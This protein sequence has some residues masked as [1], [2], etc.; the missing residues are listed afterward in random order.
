GRGEEAAVA[1]ATALAEERK[2]AVINHEQGRKQ[3]FVDLEQS[4]DNAQRVRGD[5]AVM[6]HEAHE[7]DTA[8]AERERTIPA[9]VRE[10]PP[11]WA[12]W[13]WLMIAYLALFRRD[14]WT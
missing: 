3:A 7:T 10:R 6:E 1:E 2:Q 4:R 9:S 5:A 13:L 11:W 8:I 12:F 14:E